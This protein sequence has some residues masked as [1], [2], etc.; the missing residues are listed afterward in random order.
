VIL[1]RAR[2]GLSIPGCLNTYR[3]DAH[4]IK[5]W[6]HG[7]EMNPSNIVSLCSFHHRKVHEGGI[8]IQIPRAT[9]ERHICI[10]ERTAATRWAG[11]RCD[12]GLGAEMLD[13]L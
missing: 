4:H 11:G 1:E 8:H 5:L 9:R 6:A 7:G 12:Y 13:L 3:I 2:Q 10:D